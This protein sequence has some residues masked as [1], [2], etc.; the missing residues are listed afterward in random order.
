MK[1]EIFHCLP[2]Y[3]FLNQYTGWDWWY[4]YPAMLSNFNYPPAATSDSKGIITFNSL[5]VKF[6]RL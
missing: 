2:Q 4:E 1:L 6:Y 5:S 3:W